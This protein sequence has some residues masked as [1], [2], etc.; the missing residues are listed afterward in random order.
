MQ[1]YVSCVSGA[2]MTTL[3]SVT[4]VLTDGEIQVVFVDTPGMFPGQLG[5]EEIIEIMLVDVVFDFSNEDQCSISNSKNVL[6]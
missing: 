3:E 1:Q 4:G 5:Y 2:R 6:Y